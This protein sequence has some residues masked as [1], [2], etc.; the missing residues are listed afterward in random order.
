MNNTKSI[1]WSRGIS[2]DLPIVLIII[3]KYEDLDIVYERIKAHEYWR[4]KGV[5]VDLVIVSKEEISYSHPLWNNICDVVCSS[6]L[7][8]LQNIS[9]GAFLLRGE[10]LSKDEMEELE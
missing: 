7:G 4:T 10:I 9:G 3:S 8:M 5:F 1:L 6:H 2:G